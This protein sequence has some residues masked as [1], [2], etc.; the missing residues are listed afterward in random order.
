MTTITCL[1]NTH[2][3][4]LIESPKMGIKSGDVWAT[5]GYAFA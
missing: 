3:V 1:L 5:E 4:I 2:L